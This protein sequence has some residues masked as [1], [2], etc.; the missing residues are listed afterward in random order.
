MGQARLFGH[1]LKMFTQGEVMTQFRLTQDQHDNL[2]M[3]FS[4]LPQDSADHQNYTF[5]ET[6]LVGWIVQLIAVQ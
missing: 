1:A 4:S 2:M 3:S 5:S 6:I